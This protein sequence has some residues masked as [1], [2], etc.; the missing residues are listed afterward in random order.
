[1]KYIHRKLGFV[2]STL[3]RLP[4]LTAA[5]AFFICLAAQSSSAATFVVNTPTDA[6]DINTADTV[7]EATAG[8][9]DCTLRAAISQANA[10]AG[11]D[12]ITLPAGTYT[13][14]N[15]VANNE[16]AN[17]NGDLDFTSN[18]TLNGAGSGTTFIEG[19]AAPNTAVERVIDIQGTVATVAVIINGVTIRNGSTNSGSLRGG[20]VRNFATLTVND[21]II[22]SNRT[23]ST[24]ATAPLGGGVDNEGG[25]L[26]L[27][28]VDVT[29]NTC[30]AAAATGC[31]GAGIFIFGAANQTVNI[32]N[33]RITNN[34]GTAGGTNAS[35]SGAGI[36]MQ[37]GG[38]FN[39]TGS[40]ISGNVGNGTG[41]GG[42]A[43]GTGIRYLAQNTAG[44]A[45]VL[46]V[47]DS[48]VSGNG[49]TTNGT[50]HNGAGVYIA[51]LAA[52][53]TATFTGTLTN[54]TITGNIGTNQGAGA[55]IFN[56]VGTT[57]INN[58][59]IT[60]NS[61]VSA[62]T[63]SP[64]G[65]GVLTFSGAN[66]TFNNTTVSGNS[67]NSATAGT[68]GAGLCLLGG[69]ATFN[70]GS[71]TGNTAA[72]TF[73]TGAGS[74]GGI[75]SEDTPV[76]LNETTVSGNSANFGAGI[77]SSIFSVATTYNIN[78]SA[79]VNNTGTISASGG[80][81][82]GGLYN[83]S[84]NTFAA[85]MNLNN[86]TVSGNTSPGSGGGVLNIANN[87]GNATVN[88]NFSTVASN[89]ANSDN[90]GTEGGGGINNI[91]NASTG[92]P[93]VNLTSSVV[94][95]NVVGTG[96][97]GPDIAGTITSLN[98]NHVENVT[99]GT[100]TPLA[101]DVTGTDPALGA[102]GLNG[103]STLNHLPNA[104]SP[105]ID[106]IPNGTNGCGTAPFNVDQRNRIRPIDSNNDGTAACEKGS[107]EVTA[108]TAASVS[109]SGR[110]NTPQGLGLRN[111]LVTL[112]DSQGKS[113]TI[114]TGRLGSFQF[115]DVAAGQSYI[116]SVR[117]K[118]YTFAPQ[119]IDVVDEITGL[120]FTAQ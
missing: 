61:L 102:L 59:R 83:A 88:V 25:V 77:N 19:N 66:V 10:Q 46:N 43:G 13:L 105:L 78:R 21:S 119:F 1:M 4:A 41:T 24:T 63:T 72:S 94:A 64:L 91:T 67:V 73:A 117:S 100:F 85:N 76:T 112:T 110:V 40:T 103:G 80:G 96:G 23:I 38:T 90:N 9:G 111:A 101:N 54:V 39:I 97:V 30:S 118:R 79:I 99:G 31:T 34:I 84:L 3:F 42:S 87:T 81:A 89:T 70:N 45:N 115:T 74:G 26:T 5:L 86:S 17:V 93:A 52:G 22:S 95:D 44:L 15:T 104:G 20:G 35:A 18:I 62:T 32:I 57:T 65:G 60:N 92:I 8:M 37:S 27:N 47:T 69:T 33:S 82:G 71:I 120:V 49:N 16:S 51:A 50:S 98:Y 107:V 58:S 7:C 113:R 114:L 109:I 29:G 6:N 28:N 53:S 55:Q 48:I 75:Y 14:N 106:T 56:P 11:D 36:T 116:I 108:P 2:N 68:L 12:I